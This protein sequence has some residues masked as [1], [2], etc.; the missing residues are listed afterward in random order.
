MA[1][2][3]HAAAL[4]TLAALAHAGAAAPPPH[5]LG[6]TAWPARAVVAPG[7]AQT[8]HVRNGGGRTLVVDAGVAGFALDLRGAPRVLPAGA[9]RGWVAVR[10]GLLR[11]APGASA[12]V[13]ARAR[14]P[15][16]ARPGDHPALVLLRTRP[17]AATSIGV[18][19]RIGV[20]VDV[21]VP[22]R[23]IRRL[24]VKALSVSRKGRRARLVLSVA[25]TGDL[26][27]AFGPATPLDLYAGR[28]R[29]ARLRP[30]ERELLP[31][32]SGLVVFD[33]ARARHGRLRA[34]LV[35]RGAARRVFAVRL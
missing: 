14:P 17:I 32:S 33:Y 27:A 23:A 4:V 7:A 2:G 19:V 1:A 21:R 35:A 8:I 5:Q 12:T 9:A 3:A 29:V 24:E 31:H 18:L 34:L 22:G 20:V 26:T 16:S 25:N 6:L 10:P 15:A 11:L 28:R 30:L 13:V